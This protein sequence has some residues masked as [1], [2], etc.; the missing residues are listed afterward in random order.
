M[1]HPKRNDIATK[2]MHKA[3][4]KLRRRRPTA[5]VQD[6]GFWAI[7]ERG[8][9]ITEPTYRRVFDGETDPTSC[10]LELLLVLRDF[11]EATDE[12]LGEH[13]KARLSVLSRF[14][15]PDGPTKDRDTGPTQAIQP[16]PWNDGRAVDATVLPFR[17][18]A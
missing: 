8:V 10:D 4:T 3:L 13:A 14:S 15:R 17:R 6:I 2:E 18:P 1:A 7:A 9:R 12:E 11:F 5:T 16:S